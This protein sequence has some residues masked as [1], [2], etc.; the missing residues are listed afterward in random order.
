L[1]RVCRDLYPEEV[2]EEIQH[3]FRD[4]LVDDSFIDLAYIEDELAR[5][6]AM[7]LAKLHS[8][9]YQ[10]LQDTIAELE[11]WASFQPAAPTPPATTRKVG[12]NEPCPYGSGKKYK[13][14]HGA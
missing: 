7:V 9:R 13:K 14:C 10:R 4:G 3:A 8:H 11:G 2:F 5:G 6:K 12:R 1:K